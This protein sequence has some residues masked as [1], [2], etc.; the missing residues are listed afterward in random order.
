VAAESFS[1]LST[2]ISLLNDGPGRR[3]I[4]FTS[5]HAGEGKTFCAINCAASF[6]QLGLKTLLID[7]DFRLPSVGGIFLGRKNAPG[8]SD[9]LLEQAHLGQSVHLTEIENLYVMPAGQRVPRPAELFSKPRLSAILDRVTNDFDRVVIDTAPVHLVSDTLL[10]VKHVH[11]VCLVIR[12]GETPAEDV[13]RTARR[14]AEAGAPPVGFVWNQ[15]KPPKGYHQ[16]YE[17]AVAAGE[18]RRLLR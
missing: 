13:L 17:R 4:L 16:Y 10:L 5:A 9:L 1:T 7:A 18:S 3:K 12:A 6:A 2:S 8:M 11:Y 15:V 14:L